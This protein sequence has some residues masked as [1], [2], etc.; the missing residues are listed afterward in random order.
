MLLVVFVT[1]YETCKPK[2]PATKCKCIPCKKG[3]PKEIGNDMRDIWWLNIYDVVKNWQNVLLQ[4]T[5][6]VIY[7]I[8]QYFTENTNHRYNMMFFL[9][10]W[11]IV[12]ISDFPSVAPTL[13][14]A[15]MQ[16]SRCGNWRLSR[17]IVTNGLFLIQLLICTQM[18]CVR[19][20]ISF[21]ISAKHWSFRNTLQ[22]VWRLSSQCCFWNTKERWHSRQP[23]HCVI[24]NQNSVRSI[25]L[26]SC[27][28]GIVDCSLF[29]APTVYLNDIASLE[30]QTTC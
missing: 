30:W 9:L 15:E 16:G 18:N 29:R 22:T 20:M 14:D 7:L 19:T 25:S 26:H 12:E 10:P 1:L 17:P 3:D 11:Q 23:S 24:G 5:P 21:D 8:Y 2:N 13:R 28:C 4:I 6:K 27:I